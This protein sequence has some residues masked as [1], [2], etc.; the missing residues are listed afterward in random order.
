MASLVALEG[1]AAG[2]QFPLGESRLVS[3]GRD[4][5]CSIQILDREVSRKHLQIR[6]DPGQTQH[7]AADYRSANGVFINDQLL[8]A[9]VPLADGD[10]IKLGQ[11]TLV[12]SVRDFDDDETAMMAFRKKDEWKRSTIIR[13]DEE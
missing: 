11:T 10:R 7:F 8:V 9:D 3:I 12:Y 5:D 1:P 2:R 6:F 13:R 4:D